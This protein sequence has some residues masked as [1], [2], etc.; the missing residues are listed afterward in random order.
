M[1]ATR[2][3]ADAAQRLLNGTEAAYLVL[4][5]D[6]APHDEDDAPR[7]ASRLIGCR[8]QWFGRWRIEAGPHAGQWAMVPVYRGASRRNADET[9]WVPLA[10]LR[11]IRVIGTSGAAPQGPR[12][13]RERPVA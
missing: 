3:S 5:A 11:E 7:W 2:S 4:E 13:R 8:C 9:R 10:H 1:N 12:T 6:Y